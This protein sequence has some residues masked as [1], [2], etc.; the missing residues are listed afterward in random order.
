[1]EVVVEIELQVDV[2]MIEKLEIFG[3]EIPLRT[4]QCS[5][6]GAEPREIETPYINIYVRT[7]F[8]NAKCQFCTF[9]NTAQKFNKNKYIECI[10]ELKDKVRIKKIAF[11]GGEP[12]LYWDQFKDMVYTA[13]EMIPNSSISMNTDGLRLRR[14]FEDDIINVINNIAISRHHYDDDKNNEIF[15]TK[16]PTTEELKW[17]A[18]KAENKYQ[19]QISC[20]LIKG[21]ID[22]KDEVFKMLEWANQLEINNVGL[23]SLMPVNK[24]S[25]EHFINFNVKDLI[26]ENFSVTKEWS[27]KNACQCTNYV[28]FPDNLRQPMRVYHKNTFQ[29]SDIN[30]TIIF[31]GENVLL[32]FDG[33]IIA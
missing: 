24:Y 3:R 4:H 31:D 21:Y 30:E 32:G 28:Y 6:F 8:C 17:A 23:V 16:T 25:R 15:G 12:T 29:P 10:N 9:A 7:K 14:L 22:N 11:T 5:L 1:M 20:N 27:Y 18:S 26:G 33:E 2:N 19:I 13:K